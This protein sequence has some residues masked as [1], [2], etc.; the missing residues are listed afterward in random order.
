MLD[1]IKAQ[2]SKFSSTINRL[3]SAY[4]L[5]ETSRIAVIQANSI[6]KDTDMAQEA[7]TYARN[8]ILK[9]VCGSLLAQANIDKQT[10]LTLIGGINR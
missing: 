9:D 10:A 5:N 1:T 6:I 4:K 7:A 3:E 2:T 8:S